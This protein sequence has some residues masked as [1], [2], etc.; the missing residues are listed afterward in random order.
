MNLESMYVFTGEEVIKDDFLQE[1]NNNFS[2]NSSN[3]LNISES[4][5]DSTIKTVNNKG[6]D[7]NN[8][9]NVTELIPSYLTSDT[10]LNNIVVSGEYSYSVGDATIT[11]SPTANS[12]FLTVLKNNNSIKQV[13]T[14]VVSD[15]PI[16]FTRVKIGEIWSPWV[17]GGKVKTINNIKPDDSGNVD[18][19]PMD[20]AV[21]YDIGMWKPSEEVFLGDVRYINGRE[22]AG[23]VLECIKA[24]TTGTEQPIV[25]TDNV[26]ANYNAVRIG[27]MR[28]IFNLAE[29]DEDE[30]IALGVAYNRI[31]YSELWN[32][33]QS[34]PNLVISEEEWQAKY[35]E[36]NGKFVPYYSSGNGTTT[37]RTPLLSAY[38]KGADSVEG[39]GSY[40]SAGL[41]QIE[42]VNKTTINVQG[43]TVA[44]KA[45]KVQINSNGAGMYPAFTGYQNTSDVGFNLQAN[46]TVN[47]AEIVPS[48]EIYGNSTTVQPESMIG[49]WVIK[50]FGLVT[51]NGNTDIS[52]IL[53]GVSETERR[54]EALENHSTGATVVESYRNGTEWYR[55]WSDGWLEQ[56]G[57]HQISVTTLS[58]ITETINLLKPFSDTN[59]FVTSSP[60]MVYTSE[61]SADSPFRWIKPFTTYFKYEMRNVSAGPF[62]WY[63]CGMGA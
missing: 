30:L 36:T 42:L 63:A 14:E 57:T 46:S 59:Y 34:R 37:F 23:I 48:D 1:L 9:I 41:P 3:L 45:G 28:M 19:A 21:N 8:N 43:G 50:A 49:I 51:N 5:K 18:L 16:T 44:S 12:F 4:I 35:A 29:K 25:N 10:D 33:V 52:N 26:I 15:D 6:K 13:V 20:Y 22:N 47:A 54:V 38:I 31:T 53:S 62:S 32:Y 40:L 7:A 58:S 39:V 55:V 17:E 24:G 61:P 60:I 2:K 27:S 56:G 11:N